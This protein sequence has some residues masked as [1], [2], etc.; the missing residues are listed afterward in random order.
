MTQ[1]KHTAEPARL[2][3]VRAVLTENVDGRKPSSKGCSSDY[4]RPK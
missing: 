3:L 1:K 4:W 2:D